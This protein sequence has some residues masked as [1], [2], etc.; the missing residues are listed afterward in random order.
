MSTGVLE[1]PLIPVTRL[2]S[3]VISLAVTGYRRN[4]TAAEEVFCLYLLRSVPEQT[5][6]DLAVLP[7]RPAEGGCQLYRRPDY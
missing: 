1:R 6:P 5:G 7:A 2:S 3:S 4:V